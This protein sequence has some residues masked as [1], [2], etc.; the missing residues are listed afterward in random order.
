MN[1]DGLYSYGLKVGD[2]YSC[3]LSGSIE[4]TDKELFEDSISKIDS[5]LKNYKL[6]TLFPL[7]L[8]LVDILCNL[9]Y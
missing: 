4:I 3:W 6:L 9:Y 5:P 7:V 1:L 8:L 2:Y